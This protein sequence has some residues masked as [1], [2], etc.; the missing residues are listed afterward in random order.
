MRRGS[1]RTVVGP[2]L[3]PKGL[4]P[5]ELLHL[6]FQGFDGLP[7]LHS[8]WFGLSAYEVTSAYVGVI[9]LVLA[10]TALAVRWRRPEVRSFA[11]V[12]VVM[13]LLVFAPPLV[14]FLDSSVTRI[15]WIFALTPMVLAVAV[16]SGIGMD[17]LVKS[18]RERR[19]RR[20][21][22]I[23]FG[24]MAVLLGIIWLVARRGLTPSQANIRSHSFIWP[25]VEVIAGLAVV[26]TLARVATRT[27][28]GRAVCGRRRE[29]RRVV[30]PPCGDRFP[31]RFGRPP[32][33][34]QLPLPNLDSGGRILTACRW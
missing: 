4:P 21:L 10:A 31:S 17:V 5:N 34:V 8:Q 29:R 6:I 33:L 1:N 25:T 11:S 22:G 3:F 9:V 13:G 26:W 7:L 2:D 15:Y 20:V 16:L 24:A 28:T 32:Y 30:A 12:A 18:H 14:S 23:G 19:V 27:Q